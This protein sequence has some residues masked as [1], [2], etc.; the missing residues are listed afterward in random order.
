M[1]VARGL[2][3]REVTPIGPV[4]PSVPH[5]T[6]LVTDPGRPA[7]LRCMDPMPRSDAVARLAVARAAYA[8]LRPRVVEGAP[9]PLSEDFGTGP[10]ASWGP[11]EVLA[12]LAEM[13]P[14]W[15]GQH[16]RIVEAGRGPGGG[17][18]FGRTADDHVRAVVLERDRQFPIG[19]LFDLIDDGIARWERRTAGTTDA[20]GAAVGLHPRLG[21]MTADEMRDRFVITHL[22]E[23][24]DQLQASLGPG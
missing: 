8:T 22:E 1:G 9:W 21:E 5:Q 10:E 13:L 12:H 6:G 16:G 14:F 2:V 19:D 7:T 24:L 15:Y 17:I 3:A 23:H 11:P 4:A 20:E 18:P